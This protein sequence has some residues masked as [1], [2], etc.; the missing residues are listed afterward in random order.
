MQPALRRGFQ[1]YPDQPSRSDQLTNNGVGGVLEQKIA[2]VPT[3]PGHYQLPAVEL[4]WWDIAAGKWRHIHLAA[5]P[6]DV[7]PAAN[8]GIGNSPVPTKKNPEVLIPPLKK[9]APSP[10]EEPPGASQVMPQQ[11]SFW[12]WLSL[13]LAIGWLLS[14]LVLMRRR[15]LPVV[16]AIKEPADQLNEKTARQAVLQAARNNDSAATRQALRQWSQTLFPGLVSGAYE[17]FCTVADPALK[18]ELATLDRSLYGNSEELWRGEGLAKMI[19]VWQSEKEKTESFKLP[20][21]Y[22]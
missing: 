18:Q 11:N 15:P 17:Q 12:P 5:L 6:V 19:A 3:Q 1:S 4:D 9:G 8:S 13:A 20:D 16:T 10:A 21:L 2:L 7:A 14:V 22:P